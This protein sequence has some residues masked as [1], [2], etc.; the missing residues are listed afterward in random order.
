VKL[1]DLVG[2]GDRVI[3]GMLPVAAAGI[4]ANIIWPGAFRMGFGTGGLIAGIVFLALGGPLWSWAVGQILID[5]PRGRLITTGP[6]SLVLHPI[7]TFV[8]LLVIPGV[9]LVLDTW[10]GFAIGVAL[11]VSSRIFAPSEERQLARDFPNEYPAYRA[12]VFLPWL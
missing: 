1:K 11:Y 5:V 12:R 4:A 9:G 7:Y 6:F 8:A 3:A 2:A 10:V